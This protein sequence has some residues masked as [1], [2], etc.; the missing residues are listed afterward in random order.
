MTLLIGEF[1]IYPPADVRPI[2][3]TDRM[4]CLHQLYQQAGQISNDDMLYTLSVLA[5]FPIEWVA[6][7]KWRRLNE[8]AQCA[9]G[10]FW[11]A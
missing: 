9:M 1:L 2:K 4:N 11:K 6:R 5:S 10:T 3:A 7:H 8:L